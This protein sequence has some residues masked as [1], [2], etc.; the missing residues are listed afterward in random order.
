M[1]IRSHAPTEL[2]INWKKYQMSSQLALFAIRIS[3]S[4]IWCNHDHGLMKKYALNLRYQK[5]GTNFSREY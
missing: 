2:K 4:C 3:T 5:D 1:G